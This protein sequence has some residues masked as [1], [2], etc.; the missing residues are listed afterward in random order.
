MNITLQPVVKTVNNITDM[1]SC[2]MTEPFP[3]TLNGVGFLSDISLHRM[4][5]SRKVYANRKHLSD[6]TEF[7][8]LEDSL[9]RVYAQ[10]HHR[11]GVEIKIHKGKYG[12]VI[13]KV[14]SSQTDAG[15][16]LVELTAGDYLLEFAY[17]AIGNKKLPMPQECVAIAVEIACEPIARLKAED[18]ITST[19]E[20]AE[21]PTVLT[22]KGNSNFYRVFK[23]RNLVPSLRHEMKFTA[24]KESLLLLRIK[25]VVCFFFLKKE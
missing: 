12:N 13:E 15:D 14:S 2:D 24:E 8:I 6:L 9:F 7:T 3:S 17:F 5:L 25:Y 19:C 11:I 23:T 4:H 1:L 16:L 21:L 20:T 22:N 18:A 10:R